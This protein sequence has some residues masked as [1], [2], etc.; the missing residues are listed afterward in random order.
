MSSSVTVER[1]ELHADAR[2][3]VIE[4]VSEGQLQWAH[5]T[6]IVLTEAGGIR[7][8]HLHRRATEIFVAVGPALVRW[9]EAGQVHEV[10]V[11]DGE[12]MR[13]TIPAGIP[14]ASKNTGTRPMVL[15]AFSSQPHDRAN[16]DTVREVV[17]EG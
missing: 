17:I 13:F 9:R 4:P 2:G 5:N 15:M 8:N 12:A 16:P 11:P 14:H 10:N 7:G 1:V 3:W 6:H